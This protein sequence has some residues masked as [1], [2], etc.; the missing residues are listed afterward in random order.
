MLDALIPTTHFDVLNQGQLARPFGFF[1]HQG[2]RAFDE[3][4]VGLVGRERDA[5]LAKQLL[6]FLEASVVDK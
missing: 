3:V 4:G 5:V 6:D 2:V 1:E